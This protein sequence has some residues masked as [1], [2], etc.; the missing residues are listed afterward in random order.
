[1]RAA[2]P[3]VI[4]KQTDTILHSEEVRLDDEKVLEAWY[5]DQFWHMQQI[6][7][8]IIAKAWIKAVH[9]KKQGKF[10][11]NGGKRAKELKGT[12]DF[13]YKRGQIAKPDWW[14]RKVRHQEPDH[15]D[16]RS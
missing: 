6:P 13:E 2:Q 12:D 1:M 11:Y 10:P 3:Q 4:P 7:C 14:P 16:A 8:K 9:P 15:L 5:E